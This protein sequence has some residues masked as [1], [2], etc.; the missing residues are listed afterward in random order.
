MERYRVS[1]SVPSVNKRK[2]IMKDLYFIIGKDNVSAWNE[3]ELD[4]IDLLRVYHKVFDS[5]KEAMTFIDGLYMSDKKG[6]NSSHGNY[7][8]L[9]ED[10]YRMLTT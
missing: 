2:G 4:E 5:Q 6:N 8:L 9:D 3:N 7:L 1:G 10:E